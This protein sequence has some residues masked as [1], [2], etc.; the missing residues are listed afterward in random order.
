MQAMK[1]QCSWRWI[2]FYIAIIMAAL[3]LITPCTGQERT[4]VDP[5]MTAA[6]IGKVLAKARASGSLAYQGQCQDRG[7]TWDLP[8]VSSPKYEP[9][10]VQML[11]E[12]FADDRKMQVTQD[13]NGNIRM[14]ETDV[15]RDLLDLKIVQVPFS[16]D[17]G[18]HD[19]RWA[20]SQIMVTPD[21]KNYMTVNNIGPVV[22]DFRLFIG[23]L[24]PSAPKISGDLY[25]VT[26]SEALDYILKTYPGFWAY[27][28]CT[29]KNASREVF[30]QF[31]PTVSEEVVKLP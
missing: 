17:S 8:A 27:E 9:N 20:I 31:F 3:A 11:R 5:A 19:P 15:R 25:F 18:F 10:P 16:S 4:K 12:M 29:A 26:V 30:F 13:T 21:V 24:S 23:P 14:V 7:G 28:E 6:M 1:E 22:S 2:V